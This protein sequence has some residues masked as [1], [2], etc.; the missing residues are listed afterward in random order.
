MK[1]FFGCK[2]CLNLVGEKYELEQLRDA[3]TE[4][5]ERDEPIVIFFGKG[6]GACCPL[7]ITICIGKLSCP[8]KKL[9]CP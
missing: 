4:V 2:Q 6:R 7:S 5:I 3:L 1:V 8:E 9:S